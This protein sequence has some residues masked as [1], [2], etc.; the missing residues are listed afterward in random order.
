MKGFDSPSYFRQGTFGNPADVGQGATTNALRG[1]ERILP[2]TLDQA[3][4]LPQ[5]EEENLGPLETGK[6][7]KR[8]LEEQQHGWSN[9]WNRGNSNMDKREFEEHGAMKWLL[10]LVP[11][12]D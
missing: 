11:V 5:A 10:N 8:R 9:G 12:S 3:I 2:A 4:S 1:H 7:F 6:G